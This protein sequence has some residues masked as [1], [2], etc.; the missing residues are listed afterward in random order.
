VSAGAFSSSKYS[1]NSGNIYKIRVQPET[2]QAVIDGVSNAAPAGAIDQEISASV[3]RGRRT[4]GMNARTVTF[5]FTGALPDGYNG[6]PISIPVLTQATFDA[7][8][9]TPD[10]TGTYLE[11]AVRVAGSAPETKR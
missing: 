11:V 2:I 8:T 6:T 4:V 7:W 3:S 5:A 9:G 10:K 1:A